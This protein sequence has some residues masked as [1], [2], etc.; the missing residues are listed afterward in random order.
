MY[1]FKCWHSSHVEKKNREE[2]LKN[3]KNKENSLFFLIHLRPV[4]EIIVLKTNTSTSKENNFRNS[5]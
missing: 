4:T 5:A 3:K 1:L 2:N